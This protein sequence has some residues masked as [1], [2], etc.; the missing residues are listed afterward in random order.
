MCTLHMCVYWVE[1]STGKIRPT[2]L[3]II[4]YLLPSE[5]SLIITRPKLIHDRE[6]RILPITFCYKIIHMYIY[7]IEFCIINI[8]YKSHR[9]R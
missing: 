1:I 6:Q 4:L 2:A 9:S 7:R 3:A 5:P 8:I